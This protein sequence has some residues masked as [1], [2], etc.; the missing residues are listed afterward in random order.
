MTVG[1]RK[2]ESAGKADAPSLS[3]TNGCDYTNMSWYG[4]WVEET[5]C[6]IAATVS[7]LPLKENDVRGIVEAIDGKR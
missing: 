6:D 4:E 5:L 2:T 3:V 1:D 7:I